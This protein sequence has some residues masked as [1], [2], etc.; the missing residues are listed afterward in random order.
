MDIK[1]HGGGT[2]DAKE[3]MAYRVSTVAAIGKPLTWH[4]HGSEDSEN[5][6]VYQNFGVSYNE[7]QDARRTTEWAEVSAEFTNEYAEANDGVD[8]SKYLKPSEDRPGRNGGI[9]KADFEGIGRK[10][11][12]ALVGASTGKEEE[13]TEYVTTLEWVNAQLDGFLVSNTRFE[14]EARPEKPKKVAA[15]SKKINEARE[16]AKERGLSEEDIEEI[17]GLQE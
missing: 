4:N 7:G 5:P 9:K 15:V 1:L 14:S 11:V 17:F 6:A 12:D 3:I 2:I 13:E 16:R 10:V 8:I